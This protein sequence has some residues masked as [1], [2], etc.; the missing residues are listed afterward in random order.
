MVYYT[1]YVGW[2]Q[3]YIVNKVD[4]I[5]SLRQFYTLEH[6]KPDTSWVSDSVFKGK[7]TGVHRCTPSW[8]FT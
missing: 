2:N 7:V 3:F 4:Y 8:L 6:Y 5:H 1:I